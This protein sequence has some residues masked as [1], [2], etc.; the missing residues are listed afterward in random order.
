MQ[1][2]VEV[3]ASVSSSNTV[4]LQHRVKPETTNTWTGW[5]SHGSQS[6]PL[7]PSNLEDLAFSYD[8]SDQPVFVTGRGPAGQSATGY[9]SYDGNLK[10]V[11]S[12][13]SG[14][15]IYNVYNAAGQ[16]VH[17]SEA[18]GSQPTDY[19]SASGLALARVRGGVVHYSHND[20]LGSVAARTSSA[21]NLDGP[22][23]HFTP[24]GMALTPNAANDNQAA[25][26]GHIRDAATGLTYMQARYYDPNIG[27]FLSIDPV[28]FLDNG[29]PGYFNRY[30]YTFNDPIN[31][32]DPDGQ[33]VFPRENGRTVIVYPQKTADHVDKRHSPNGTAQNRFTQ[34]LG[35][36]KGQIMAMR[37]IETAVADGTVAPDGG[38]TVYEGKL[39]GM[40]TSV[41][42]QGED[43][44]RVVTRDLDTMTDPEMLGQVADELATPE[45]VG[46]LAA[47]EAAAPANADP[48][49]VEVIVTQYP[50]HEEDRVT[51]R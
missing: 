13:A 44:N 48:I 39:G 25:F 7:P 1:Y 15:T 2:Y 8:Y 45:A 22:V 36:E 47:L 46:T 49:K 38:A 29:N 11:K 9:Y 51:G 50:V 14:Q 5:T 30:A 6:C 43:T 16:L 26:T 3:K 28:T 34:T 17:V 33:Q 37:T 40:F 10:R 18:G 23:E 32:I 24:F 20:H 41:G 21:G 42:T 19:I 31:N 4:S 12:T 35:K 27:R